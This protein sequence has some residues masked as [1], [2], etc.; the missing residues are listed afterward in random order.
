MS[1]STPSR[2]HPLQ[3]ALHWL[4][5]LLVIA[6]LVLGKITSRLPNDDAAKLTPMGIHMTLGIVTLIVIFARISLRSK[7]PQPAYASTGNV[8]LD[9]F[10]KLVHVS[11]YLLA[12]T[13]GLSGIVLSMQA[14]LAPIVFFGSGNP[15]PADFFVYMTRGVHGVVAPTLF[16]LILIH[17]GAAFYHQWFIKDKLFSRMW[18]GK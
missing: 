7:Y 6:A 13:M 1:Q 18:F 3:I 9:D 4:T 10:G 12:A 14:G 11:L 16:V 2:Y 15:L 5:V 8:F 17:F